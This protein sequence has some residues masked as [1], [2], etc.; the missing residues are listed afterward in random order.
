MPTLIN[1]LSLLCCFVTIFVLHK[2]KSVVIPT[3]ASV[4]ACSMGE[5]G[6]TADTF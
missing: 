6:F 1:K 2:S 3:V 4:L 5:S